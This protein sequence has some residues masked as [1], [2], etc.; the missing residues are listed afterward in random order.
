MYSKV[1]YS[2]TCNYLLDVDYSFLYSSID[3]EFLWSSL[4]HIIHEAIALFVPYSTYRVHP[5]P[6]L[7]TPSLCHSLN[8]LHSVRHKSQNSTHGSNSP[9][10][11]NTESSFIQQVSEAKVDYETNL[12]KN[13]ATNKGSKSLITFTPSKI[14]LFSLQL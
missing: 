10:L 14:H 3:T 11:M 9:L 2:G 6:K 5:L 13:Y 7:F 1:N 4:K 8:K 12:I